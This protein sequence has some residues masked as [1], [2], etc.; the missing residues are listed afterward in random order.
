MHTPPWVVRTS[1][2]MVGER[3]SRIY[4]AAVAVCLAL[5]L[6]WTAIAGGPAVSFGA[7]LLELATLPWT[8][9]LW[10]LFAAVGGLDV[11]GAANGWTGWTLT[12]VAAVI[13]AALDAALI[14]CAARAARRRVAA[15]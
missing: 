2:A 13:S 14:G 8:P 7:V 3:A 4:L 1:R 6:L 12:V 5:T 9:A 10:R 11:R 15:R